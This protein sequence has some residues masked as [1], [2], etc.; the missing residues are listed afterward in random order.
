MPAIIPEDPG[1]DN[2]NAPIWH[3][4]A[5]KVFVRGKGGLPSAR[6]RRED[7]AKCTVHCTDGSRRGASEAADMDWPYSCILDPYR[8]E[9]V[10]LLPLNWTAHSLRG[11]HAKT[12]VPIE[13]NHSGV[14]H[15]QIAIRGFANYLGEL[16]QGQLDW[17]AEMFVPIVE[18]CGVPN[19]WIE[20]LGPKDVNYILA[21]T[22]SKLRPSLSECQQTSG[23]VTHQWWYGQDHWDPGYLETLRIQDKIDKLLGK[24][25]SGQNGQAMEKAIDDLNGLLNGIKHEKAQRA[26]S[27]SR[28]DIMEDSLTRILAELKEG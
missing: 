3:P 17:L 10:S 20:S 7:P 12:K 15:P 19:I 9:S 5:V 28:L 26:S 22:A 25:D 8:K 16:D 24:S 23:F 11:T 18:L 6:R 21:S 1:P 4:E 13:T 14:M 27:V 2:I